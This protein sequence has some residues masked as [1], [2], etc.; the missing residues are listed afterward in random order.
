[1]GVDDRIE[2]TAEDLKGKTKEAAGKVTDNERLEAEGKMDQA[3]ADMKNTAEDVKDAF[4]DD[5]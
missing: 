2:N 1:M 4:R 3:K 5:R